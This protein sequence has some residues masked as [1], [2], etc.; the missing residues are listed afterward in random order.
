[1]KKIFRNN[2]LIAAAFLTVFAATM[3]SESRATN[4]SHLVPVE[5]KFAGMIKNDPVFQLS[6]SGSSGQDDFTISIT[7]AAGISLYR[8]NIRAENFTK[9]FLL[10]ADELGDETLRLEILSRKTKKIVVYEISCNTRLV[11]SQ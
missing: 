11:N 1:M 3:V 4:S 2:R 7:D 10:N 8:E 6:V 5:L 9:K